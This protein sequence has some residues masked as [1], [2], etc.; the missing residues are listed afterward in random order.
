MMITP[1]RYT[2]HAIRGLIT[3][4]GADDKPI[5]KVT[6]EIAAGEF[7]G[8]C[9]EWDGW[10]T[11][12][13][14]ERTIEGL[15]L[16]GWNGDADDA[17]YVNLPGITTREVAIEVKRETYT[18][19]DGQTRESVKVAWVNDPNSRGAGPKP[20]DR[21][22]ALAFGAAMRGAVAAARGKLGKLPEVKPDT[23]FSFGANAPSSKAGF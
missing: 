5:A 3:T 10:L 8:E 1:G 18:G 15:L 20:M 11:D 19:R 17:D 21:V 9:V 14:R 6:F 22:A 2:A 23:S 13:A 12:K 16:C 7:V 4:V